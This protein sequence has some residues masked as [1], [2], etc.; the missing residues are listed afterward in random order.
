MLVAHSVVFNPLCGASEDK[1]L[2]LS[3]AGQTLTT[4][5]LM[6]LNRRTSP[7]VGGYLSVSKDE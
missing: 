5:Q 4:L 6:V 3:G 7:V 1:A 2:Q